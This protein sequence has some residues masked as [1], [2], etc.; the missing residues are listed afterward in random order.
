MSMLCSRKLAGKC[1]LIVCSS[2]Q[3]KEPSPFFDIGSQEVQ[4]KTEPQ[5]V[6]AHAELGVVRKLLVAFV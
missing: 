4:V 1:L 2:P 3:Q 6:E 5:S